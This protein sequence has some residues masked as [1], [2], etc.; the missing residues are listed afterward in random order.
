NKLRVDHGK[1][2]CRGVPG[3]SQLLEGDSRPR[4]AVM[5]HGPVTE[6]TIATAGLRLQQTPIGTERPA[7]GSYVD[8]NRVFHDDDTGPD[9]VHQFVFGDKFAGRLG[10]NFEYP[11]GAPTN[12]HCRSKN[13]KFAPGKVNLAFARRVNRS[14]ACSEHGN[15]PS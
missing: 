8:V 12:R 13:P 6:E 9:A 14:I 11:E 15:G 1:I 5:L 10:E 7:D 4:R 2:G 3:S